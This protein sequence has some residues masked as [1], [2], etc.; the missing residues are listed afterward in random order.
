MEF[1]KFDTNIPQEM[2][3]T[4]AEGVPKDGQWGEYYFR[5]TTDGRGVSF[6]RDVE[7]KILA[8]EI[9]PGEIV[10]ICKKEQKQG[11]RR[12]IIW[13]VKRVDPPGDPGAPV[14]PV[15]I[16]AA[17][18]TQPPPAR[19]PASG[20]PPARETAPQAA[21]VQPKPNG[22]A[23]ENH[24]APAATERAPIIHTE[25]SQAIAGVL[26]AAVD[27]FLQTCEYAKSKGL[28]VEWHLDFTGDLLQRLATSAFIAV[29]DGK[30]QAL[31]LR[32][33][34]EQLRESRAANGGASW[35]H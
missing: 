26:I 18:V 7:S 13:E 33:R 28:Q 1:I 24:I 22:T 21:S 14:Q 29:M 2:A 27:G 3:F 11:N 8:L 4:H 25:L 10:S 20:A 15:A 5:T 30:P 9:Q 35:P 19:R 23:T 32:A 34:N 6:K 12:N 17:A 31:N 16:Q